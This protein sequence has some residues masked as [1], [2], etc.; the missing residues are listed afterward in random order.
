M[1]FSLWIETPKGPVEAF[2]LL[3]SGA[4]SSFVQ[5]RWAKQ[6]LPDIDATVRQVRAI[7]DTTVKSYGSRRLHLTVGDANGELRDQ[8]ETVESV[9]MLEYDIIL[10]YPWLEHVDPDVHWAK[11]CWYYRPLNNS[12]SKKLEDNLEITSAQTCAML[13]LN[14]APVYVLHARP[15]IDGD[16]IGLFS[17]SASTENTVPQEY[18]DFTHVFSEEEA[19]ILAPHRDHDHAIEL[20]HGATPPLR[21]LYALSPKEL[22]VVREYINTA[23]EKGWIRPSTSPAGAPILF[24]PKKD[25]SLRLCVDYRGLNNI[26]IKNRYPLPLVGEIM[27][28]LSGATIYTQLDL[29]DAYHRLRIRKGDEWK[30]AFRTRYGH[31][32]YQVMPFGLANAPATFQSYINRALSDLLDTHCIVY[33]DDIL[34]YSRS[35]EEH[36]K[37]VRMVLERLE[38]FRLYC[39]LSKCTFHTD[40]VNF[41]GFVIS[42]KGIKIERSR[43]DTILDW[44]APQSVH[45]ILMFLGF[46]NFYRRFIEGYSKIAAPLNEMTKNQNTCKGRR[47]FRKGETYN[48]PDF[49]LSPDALRSFEELKAKFATAPLLVH[50]DPLR[51]NRIEPDAS[52]FAMAGVYAQ[53]QD[54][55]QWHPVAFWSRKFQGA[56][57]RYHT[58]DKELLAIVESFKHWRHYLEGAQHPVVILSDHA[59][60]R[61]FMTTTEL[62]RRQA[63][64][65]EKLAAFDFTIE[66]RPGARNPADAPSRRPDYEPAKG[67]SLDANAL[68]PTLQ[69][70]LRHSSIAMPQAQEGTTEAQVA[71]MLAQPWEPRIFP[72]A[73]THTCGQ[74]EPYADESH[75]DGDTGYPEILVP[76]FMVRAAMNT[77]TAYNTAPSASMTELIRKVQ[78]K[79]SDAAGLLASLKEDRS[80]QPDSPWSM[81]S[82]GLLRYQKRAYIPKSSAIIQEI[83]KT[84]HDDPQG[85]HL[86]ERRTWQSIRSRYYWHG[87]G[88]DVKEYVQHCQKCQNIST[89]RHKPYGM[90]EPLPVP[91]KPMDWINLDEGIAFAYVLVGLAGDGS[92]V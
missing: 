38:K 8:Y 56:E 77:E 20:E 44:P 73:C 10:G 80:A 13:A 40:T 23:L 82:D 9:D 16:T 31:F 54:D 64:W 3:D 17:A 36:I 57:E 81:S 90:L 42:P 70:K 61:Y 49:T 12:Q 75:V 39:K 84:N 32:E 15:L 34:I 52:D 85:G 50:Y 79:D 67:E 65:A 27:D 83:L 48:D 24:A 92:A 26:T 72:R 45:D 53:L 37:H 33:L 4:E 62:D 25:G 29:R 88:H 19:S 87:M 46:A 59:N 30:T 1:A 55:G 7:N 76:R 74:T 2:C 71:A 86:R 51:Q 78:A 18:T 22:E 47:K 68:L 21:P 58:H 60:L 35:A 63:R 11:Q 6:Y 41:L 5:Q 66:H 14:G 69:R 28:R 43:V 89:H 91:Q